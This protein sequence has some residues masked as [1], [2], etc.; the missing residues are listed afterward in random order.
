MKGIQEALQE[1]FNLPAN[2]TAL[3]TD[4]DALK[5]FKFKIGANA[6]C[7]AALILAFTTPTLLEMVT[8]T[9]TTEYKGGIAKETVKKLFC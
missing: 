1:W 9:E 7:S 5:E 6:A 8:S 3:L 4:E 2:P